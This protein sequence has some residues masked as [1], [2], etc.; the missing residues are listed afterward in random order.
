MK[1]SISEN[2]CSIT[3]IPETEADKRLLYLLL[4]CSDLSLFSD[5]INLETSQP[6]LPMTTDLGVPLETILRY[7]ES[8][9]Q[10][11]SG[12]RRIGFSV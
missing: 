8:R 9:K 3:L 2:D 4:D 5:Y 6:G 1:H 12:S 11:Q 7:A 10:L